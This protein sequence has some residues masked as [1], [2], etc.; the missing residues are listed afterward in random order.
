[1][2]ALDTVDALRKRLYGQRV[3]VRCL[4]NEAH[5]LESLR[6]VL[7]TVLGGHEGVGDVKRVEKTDAV[8]LVVALESPDVDAPRLIA[9]LVAR[10]VSVRS[11]ADI[12]ESLEDVYLDIVGRSR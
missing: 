10:G 8:E 1:M 11:V 3:R 6:E 2:L 4:P 9:T 7:D 5:P 12:E